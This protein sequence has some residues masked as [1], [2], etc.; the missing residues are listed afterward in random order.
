M[1]LR[2]YVEL[3]LLGLISL[4][5][6]WF[7]N[8]HSRIKKQIADLEKEWNQVNTRL[9][10]IETTQMQNKEHLDQRFDV[11]D[12]KIDKLFDRFE[13]YDRDREDFFKNFD[14]TPKR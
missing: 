13:Q 5:G 8:E 4:V 10:V 2:E 3:A 12:K 11:L 1:E 14:L 6:G 7:K 9:A